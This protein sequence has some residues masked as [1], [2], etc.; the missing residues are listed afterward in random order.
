MNKE[1]NNLQNKKKLALIFTSRQK[2]KLMLQVMH[3][4]IQILNI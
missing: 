2:F 1:K 4:N 3:F